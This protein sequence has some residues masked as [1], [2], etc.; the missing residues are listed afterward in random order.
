MT[1]PRIELHL[2]RWQDTIA[3]LDCDAL[4]SDPPYGERTHAKQCHGRRKERK[5]RNSSEWASSRA[6][7]YDH[8]TPEDAAALAR[9]WAK[10]CRGWICLMTSHDLIPTYEGA[11][12][13]AGRYV[14]KPLPIVMRGM[15]VRLA[16]DGPSSW[17][18]EMIQA[19]PEI[20]FETDPDTRLLV[21]RWAA[22]HK[23]RTLPG[24]YV[25]NPFDPGENTA[26][27][28]RKTN[29]VGSKPL[30]LMKAIIAGYTNPG[31]LIID[32]FAGSGTTLIAAR[33]LGR[34]CVGA[35]VDPETYDAAMRRLEKPYTP[36]IFSPEQRVKIP[37]LDLFKEGTDASSKDRK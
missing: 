22:Q 16:G 27:A 35:E 19:A 17:S 30:W 20:V 37:N 4:I 18:V 1:E 31:D 26:T 10:Q 9:H 33:A 36:E 14:F 28:S 12:L 34:S 32:P 13:E 29:V 15:N 23:W 7:G 3:E 24:A 21:S 5:N 6:L 2:G 25:G 11:L 8:L